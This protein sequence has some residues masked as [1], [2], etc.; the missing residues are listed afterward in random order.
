MGTVLP[1]YALCTYVVSC[2]ELEQLHLQ[3][4]LNFQLAAFFKFRY[5]TK[6][7]PNDK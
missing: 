4:L 7:W 1:T 3:M 6:K 2:N 5:T